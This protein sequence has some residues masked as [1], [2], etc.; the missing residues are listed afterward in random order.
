MTQSQQ[1]P[2]AEA[3]ASGQGWAATRAITRKLPHRRR[4]LKTLTRVADASK[5]GAGPGTF[6]NR[7][8]GTQANDGRTTRLL[9]ALV[10]IAG[11]H[12]A[13]KLTRQ[14]LRNAAADLFDAAARLDRMGLCGASARVMLE[15]SHV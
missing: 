7:F 11:D 9:G 8:D 2:N 15:A 3:A 12:T 6:L 4:D 13:D 5:P 10:S 14:L 1:T